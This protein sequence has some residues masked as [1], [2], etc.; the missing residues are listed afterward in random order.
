MRPLLLA[1][2]GFGALAYANTNLT[3]S[4]PTS[5]PSK[6]VA[7]P[8]DF[9]SFGFETAF[10]PKYDNDFSE[11]IVNAIG[12]RMSKPLIIRV[13]GTSGDLVRVK[14]DLSEAT[15]CFA[16][17]GCPDNSKDS[18]DIGPSYFDGFKRF[19]N[20][21][22]TFQAPMGREMD[23]VHT[24]A[25]VKNAWNAL[26]QDRVAGIALGNE[27][28]FYNW[29]AEQYVT[30]ALEVE[31]AITKEFN[32]SGDA[33][34]IFELGDISNNASASNIPFGLCVFFHSRVRPSRI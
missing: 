2:L 31:D 10:L 26:G 21:T 6:A 28:G 25:Y 12:S 9:F 4:I 24:M 17:P 7:I 5:S 14:E 13:G 30:R 27:P 18:F 3:V 11:N 16:G 23:I 32:L 1:P 29:T 8:A 15:H 33:A 34:A 20:A 22:M 19:Q